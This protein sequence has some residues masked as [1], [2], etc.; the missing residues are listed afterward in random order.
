[1][2]VKEAVAA[3]RSGKPVLLFDS[4]DREGETDLVFA[5]QFADSAAIR[6]L[7]K[8]AG[9]LVCVAMP[10]SIAE[11][12]GIPFMTEVYR[13]SGMKIFD[14]LN[15]RDVKY[16][17]KSS[18]SITVNHRNT[19][20]GIPDNDRALTVTEF[21]NVA[22][23]AA[24]GD[25]RA[26][27][28]FT[29][30]FRSPGHVHLLIGDRN[31]IAERRGHTELSLALAE[32]GGLVPCTTIAEMLGE[33]GKSLAKRDAIECARRSGIEFVEGKEVVGEYLKRRQGWDIQQ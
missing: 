13:N 2:G 20:T 28:E 11:Y 9:G 3:L 23:L 29:E 33:D 21:S 19:F 31:M 30:N 26:V 24:R 15:D 1:M 18:F 8:E 5:S 25:S 6:M 10:Y 17:S 32:I 7:R 14:M 22:A 27:K 16:D 12:L 4:E